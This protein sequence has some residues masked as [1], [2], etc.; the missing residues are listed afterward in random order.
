MASHRIRRLLL[1]LGGAQIYGGVRTGTTSH[2]TNVSTTGRQTMVGTA[3]VRKT[4]WLP[5][6]DF[7]GINPLQFANA[8]LAVTAVAGSTTSVNP[9]GVD[10]GKGSGSTVQIPTLSASAAVNT[11]ARAAIAFLAPSDADTTGS[12]AATLYYTTELAQATTG[13]MV[14]FRL[15][16]NYTGTSGSDTGGVSGSTLTGASMT[17]IGNG[18]WEVQSLGNMASFNYAASP[19]CMIQLTDEGSSASYN[20][21]SPETK[22]LGL[23][24][25]YTANSLGVVSS[26]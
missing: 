22:I 7:Y 21:G 14:I 4:M 2:Y 9:E 11:D 6:T 20:S 8:Y 15:N 17:T 5:A 19:I 23:E 24:L 3:R 13:S 12:V 18:K 25:T 1:A 26:E 16:Y 10:F